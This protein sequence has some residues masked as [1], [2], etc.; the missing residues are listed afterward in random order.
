MPLPGLRANTVDP[1]LDPYLL[2]SSA[3]AVC[4]ALAV[5]ALRRNLI[6]HAAVDVEIVIRGS[7]AKMAEQLEQILALRAAN[8]T[9]RKLL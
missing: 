6:A 5:A 3:S 8:M 2:P 4:T 7:R 1:D 9:V